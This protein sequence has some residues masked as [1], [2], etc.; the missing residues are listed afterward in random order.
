MSV[1]VTSSFVFPLNKSE[2]VPYKKAQPKIKNADDNNKQIEKNQTTGPETKEK[3]ENKDYPTK[4]AMSL[5]NIMSSLLI[6][7]YKGYSLRHDPMAI[8]YSLQDI[9]TNIG[10]AEAAVQN[11]K[12][13][14]ENLTDS[15][16]ETT[17][18]VGA[19]ALIISELTKRFPSMSGS[20]VAA[21]AT[22]L[23]S[24]GIGYL[25]KK[26]TEK[27][28][29]LTDEDLKKQRI[30]V[31]KTH[32]AVAM[33]AAFKATNL[34]INMTRPEEAGKSKF[35]SNAI[36]LATLLNTLKSSVTTEL[37]HR[38]GECVRPAKSAS[39]IFFDGVISG[40]VSQ[41]MGAASK[42]L[43][44]KDNLQNMLPQV[45][46][47]SLVSLAGIFTVTKS[48]DP[49]LDYLVGAKSKPKDNKTDKEENLS[50]Q[51]IEN[52]DPNEAIEVSD[53]EKNQT[54]PETVQLSLS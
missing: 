42:N 37:A 15:I 7:G 24:E 2:G 19:S 43:G 48:L 23:S 34:Y 21:V 29:D 5:V 22:V 10:I 54:L 51:P 38:R 13:K 32:L 17:C 8:R 53:L 49:V 25:L 4:R 39:P 47:G 35:A 44:I 16:K 20:I 1:P 45:V 11:P 46:V 30:E 6:S 27:S 52:Q 36:F 3:E 14:S 50:A 40:L 26:G 41:G 9:G 31:N 18:H 28:E 12:V 33:A